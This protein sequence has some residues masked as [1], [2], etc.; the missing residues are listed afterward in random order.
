MDSLREL[1]E[2]TA[3][4]A[5]T[6]LEGID[7]RAVNAAASGPELRAAL[8]KPLPEAPTDPAR[9]VEELVEAADPGIVASAGGRYFGFVTGGSL[10][11]ALAA[12]W[13]S[14]A[15]DQ[16]GFSYVMSPAAAVVEE[17]AGS[18]L[19]ELLG[20][21]STAS[22]GF[23]TGAQMANVTA[24]AAA[25][26]FV[27]ERAGWDVARQ[28]L[29][30]S[31]PLRVFVGE[32]RHATVDTSL[33]LLGIGSEQIEIVPA[34]GH[35]RLRTAELGRALDDE[36]TIVCAQ[37]GNVNTGAFDPL[38]E[39]A[40]ATTATGAWLH[41]D[42][43][44]G[45]WAGASPRLRHLVEGVERADSWASDAH[46]WLN[47]PY[48]SGLVF[49]AHAD[50]HRAATAVVGAYLVTADAER[51]GGA[52]TPEA[53]RRTRGFPVYAA[54]RSLGRSG[55]AELV[56]RC[57]RHARR[58]AE[59]LG[60]ATDVQVLNDV[61]L[62]QVLVRFGDDDDRTR[63]VI[64]HVQ[65]E[66]TAWFGGTVWHGRAAM[67]ISVTSWRTTEKDVERS[68]EAILEAAATVSGALR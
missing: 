30:G 6:Y 55:I 45:L 10:P 64:R 25:R 21:P 5:A 16:N 57:C 36:P 9:V 67:R 13:L 32:E 50:A 40:D 3:H 7:E 31:P 63:E 18:W 47:V 61:V 2:L 28:G 56:E 8:A 39:L 20:L 53:S 4:S 66:G 38:G 23:V 22:V 62:N 26:H 59:L 68:V 15:W 37:A 29:R 35:G 14:S 42:G 19:K 34:D 1:L 12:D 43:A 27:L 65:Q 46:K 41:V 17:V 44:F 60:E 58:F 33:R 48:D 49:C 24:L 51:D 11:A 52:W 54:I